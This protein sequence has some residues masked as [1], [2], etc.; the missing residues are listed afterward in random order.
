MPTRDPAPPSPRDLRSVVFWSA[1]WLLGAGT[2]YRGPLQVTVSE[3]TSD[4]AGQTLTLRP[5]AGEEVYG[6]DGPGGSDPAAGLGPR[7]LAA[8]VSPDG[9]RIME[10]IA[11]AGPVA[12]KTIQLR[13]GIERSRLYCLLTDLRDRG[14]IADHGDGYE[15]ADPE[16]WEAVKETTEGKKAG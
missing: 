2:Y 1:R 3:G 14:L 10:V 6:P 7:L 8:L 13:A 12:A 9:R 5:K 4:Q 15:L 11:D 16:L